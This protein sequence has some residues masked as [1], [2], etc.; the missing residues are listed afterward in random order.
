MTNRLMELLGDGARADGFEELTRFLDGIVAQNP[1]YLADD[2]LSF[3]RLLK[4]MTT[5][6]TEGANQEWQRHGRSAPEIALGLCR[7]AGFA[8]ASA[9]LSTNDNDADL[10][11]LRDAIMHSIALGVDY[12]VN[13]ARDH[14][15]SP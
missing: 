1:T 4:I 15:V 7:A 5:A 9:V 11:E 8:V 13:H 12:M 10:S 2:E 3:V 14:T 6:A